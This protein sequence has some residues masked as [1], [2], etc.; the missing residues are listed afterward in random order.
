MTTDRSAHAANVEILHTAVEA[1]RKRELNYHDILEDLPAAIYT[2][3]AEGRITYFNKAC[4][5]FSGRTPRLGDDLWCVTWK[6]YTSDG[7]PLPHAECPMAVAL[8]EGR[9][10][11]GVEAIAERPDGSRI[12][13]LPY[14]TPI[15]DALGNLVGAVNMLVDITEQKQGQERLSR[16]AHEIDER[17]KAL[18]HEQLVVAE[19]Q[20]RTRNLLGLI[21]SVADRTFGDDPVVSSFNARL[22]A[23]GRLQS[24]LSRSETGELGE[25]V[26]AE[27]GA[28]SD[29]DQPRV[30][31]DGPPI[32]LPAET[33]QTLALGLHELM[34]NACKYGA[35]ASHEGRL[36]VSWRLEERDERPFLH[37]DWRESG[38][39]M[40]ER[41]PTRSGFG[42]ELIES[43]LPYQ[44]QAS[45]RLK[46]GAD[47]V[48]CTIAL[49]IPW[50]EPR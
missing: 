3:D 32:L 30:I 18:E 10:V 4:V 2:T 16:M 12:N 31:I 27:I 21:R 19:L 15:F 23:L 42:R 45:T 29:G 33:M 8:R 14:P 46:F 43:A 41:Q 22:A 5:A 40:P 38:V 11:R 34:T 1:F 36:S 17:R 28:Y 48:H 7:A 13:F 39:A 50:D 6:L 26:R 37:V 25:L 44:H 24:F 49:P 47:G 35:L 9:P 20:H